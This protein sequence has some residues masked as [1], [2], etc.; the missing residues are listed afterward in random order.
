MA[1]NSKKKKNQYLIT[2]RWYVET[3]EELQPGGKESD[4]KILNIVRHRTNGTPSCKSC[5]T[6][7]FE[8]YA[9]L[10]HHDFMGDKP[11]YMSTEQIVLEEEE[12]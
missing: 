12:K 2:M 5:P 8:N 6:R 3:D 7:S 11:I 9:I 4:E 10:K 1:E